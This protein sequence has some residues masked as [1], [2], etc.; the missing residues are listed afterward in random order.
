MSDSIARRTSGLA[1]FI[2]IVALFLGVWALMFMDDLNDRV[3]VA[4]NRAYMNLEKIE[5]LEINADLEL[6]RC[7]FLSSNQTEIRAFGEPGT[8]L[9]M[10]YIPAGEAGAVICA[11]NSRLEVPR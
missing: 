4:H 2:A 1:F 7:V 11:K 3:R 6:A 5:D 10:E 8:H 9:E